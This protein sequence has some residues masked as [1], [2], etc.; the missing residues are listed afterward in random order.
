MGILHQNTIIQFIKSTIVKGSWAVL[1]QLINSLIKEMEMIL[2]C[3][4]GPNK[5]S[6]CHLLFAEF[7]TLLILGAC[8][9]AGKIRLG[10]SEKVW[11]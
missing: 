4:F 1:V 8:E 10:S 2:L 6:P 11:T 9:G 7:I 5:N 3:C